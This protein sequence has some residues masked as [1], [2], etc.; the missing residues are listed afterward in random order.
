[1]SK[2]ELIQVDMNKLY[3]MS[4]NEVIVNLTNSR[5]T[6]AVVKVEYMDYGDCIKNWYDVY[7][8]DGIN[9]YKCDK[10]NNLLPTYVID[11]KLKEHVEE[12]IFDNLQ[13]V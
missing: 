6:K 4:D 10:F 13:F 8:T 3:E 1:M 2:F 11:G 12:I 5:F 7:F 9:V